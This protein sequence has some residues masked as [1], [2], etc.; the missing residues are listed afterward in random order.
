[1]NEDDLPLV[2]E[3]PEPRVR[4]WWIE[5]GDEPSEL[6]VFPFHCHKYIVLREDSGAAHVVASDARLDQHADILRAL[7]A[8]SRGEGPDGGLAGGGLGGERFPGLSQA[9]GPP[10]PDVVRAI[11]GEDDDAQVVVPRWVRRL[12]RESGCCGPDDLV[13]L[14][15]S[16]PMVSVTIDALA[17]VVEIERY[18]ANWKLEVAV[19]PLASIF[20]DA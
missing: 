18:D 20:E 17:A 14:A 15:E 4:F 2:D 11:Q 10:P 8:G 3:R 9:F 5:E 12:I 6:H 19:V 7:V 13:T 16:D 1:M